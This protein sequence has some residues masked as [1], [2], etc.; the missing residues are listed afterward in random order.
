MKE[1]LGPPK[2][3]L[4]DAHL[5]IIREGLEKFLPGTKAWAYGSRVKGTARRTS[6]LDM[7]VFA[8]PDLR[9]RVADLHEFFEESDLPMPVDLHVWHELPADFHRQIE[10]QYVALVE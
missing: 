4:K 10:A 6:D 7:V 3:D 2:I 8:T 5:M 9:A 1:T